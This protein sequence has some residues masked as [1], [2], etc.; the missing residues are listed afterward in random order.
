[1]DEGTVSGALQRAYEDM[2]SDDVGPLIVP[3]GVVDF[4]SAWVHAW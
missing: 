2:I 4:G 3:L 1:M